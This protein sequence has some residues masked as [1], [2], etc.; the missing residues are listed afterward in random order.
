M[1]RHWRL[2]TCLDEADREDAPVRVQSLVGR[3]ASEL[4][5]SEISRAVIE[6]VAENSVD[7]VTSSIEW[8]AVFGALGVVVHRA[9]NTFDVT[10]GHHTPRCEHFG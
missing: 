8:A 9:I 1:A 6:S 5:E 10:V 4:D 2:R 7:A 3:D